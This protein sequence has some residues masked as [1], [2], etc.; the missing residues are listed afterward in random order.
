MALC[1]RLIH[2]QTGRSPSLARPFTARPPVAPVSLGTLARGG[3]GGA[4]GK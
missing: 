4:R 1:A 2:E 3:S